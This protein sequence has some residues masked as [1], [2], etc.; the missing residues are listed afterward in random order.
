MVHGGMVTASPSKRHTQ[1]YFRNT[2]LSKAFVREWVKRLLTSS[3]LVYDQ[4]AFN[5]ACAPLHLCVT[6]ATRPPPCLCVDAQPATEELVARLSLTRAGVL[7]ARSSQSW[8]HVP[9]KW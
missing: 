6:R 4:E 5:Q 3:H 1:V 2:D 9:S 7:G 8:A